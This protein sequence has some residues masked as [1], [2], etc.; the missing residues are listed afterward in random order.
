MPQEYQVPN[1]TGMYAPAGRAFGQAAEAGV[2][3][4]GDLME[5]KKNDNL[6]NQ[7]T[8]NI[9]S[10]LDKVPNLEYDKEQFKRR[11]GEDMKSFQE[12]IKQAIPSVFT[13]ME[14]M[15]LDPRKFVTL[16]QLPGADKLMDKWI[17]TEKKKGIQKKITE[18]VQGVTSSADMVPTGQPTPGMTPAQPL[19]VPQQ[20]PF[21]EMTPD[22]QMATPMGGQSQ[23]AVQQVSQGQSMAGQPTGAMGRSGVQTSEEF[24]RRMTQGVVS[25]ASATDYAENPAAV[26]GGKA[27]PEETKLKRQE[28][29][30]RKSGSDRAR[31]NIAASKLEWDKIKFAITR[32][33]MN[34]QNE[35][36]ARRLVA[37]KKVKLIHDKAELSTV[38]SN[39]RKASSDPSF[40]EEQAQA[41]LTAA[42]PR[43]I[44]AEQWLQEQED[45][46]TE[47]SQTIPIED[48]YIAETEDLIKKKKKGG[49]TGAAGRKMVPGPGPTRLPTF[50]ADTTKPTEPDTTAGSMF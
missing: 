50:P 29:L 5:E 2:G 14:Q 4:V 9:V 33:D 21:S 44:T 1:Y 35:L 15:N 20:K 30:N 3:V 43:M 13:Q 22:E 38:E 19:A 6:A 49:V 28:Y 39:I 40:A 23:S 31:E 11:H 17:E 37:P 32:Q 7:L 10:K 36:A 8:G 12:R 47:L 42:K 48:S 41:E 46:Y 18:Q 34:E 25:E 45:K 16:A 24:N 26:F 27:Y